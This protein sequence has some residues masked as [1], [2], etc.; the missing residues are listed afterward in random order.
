MPYVHEVLGGGKPDNNFLVSSPTSLFD[1]YKTLNMPQR[2]N[3]AKQP[4]L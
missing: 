4:I 1:M 3:N 2:Y